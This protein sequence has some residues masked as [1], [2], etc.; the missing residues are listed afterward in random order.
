MNTPEFHETVKAFGKAADAIESARY[1]LKGNFLIAVANRSYYACYY[2]LTGLLYTQNIY[3]KTHQGTRA[4]FFELF[5][6]PSLFPIEIS[7]SINT[8]F[9]FRQHA[10]YD[11]DAE[12]T[13][14]DA[15]MLIE[16]AEELYRLS[17]AYF[18]QNFK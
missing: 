15:E 7:K 2:C 3:A 13:H 5:I 14:K 10:D 8:L 12:V 16:K 9:D 17:K 6:K 18:E 11:L 1:N 4:K